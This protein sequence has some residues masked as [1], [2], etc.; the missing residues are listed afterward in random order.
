[1]TLIYRIISLLINAVALMLAVSM[2]F[3]IPMLFSSPQTL[4][5]G[6]LIVAVILYS[7]FSFRFRREVLQKQNQV[8][9]SLRDWVRVNG[10]VTIVFCIISILGLV[11][12]LSNPKPFLET[13]KNFNV[14]MSVQ[15]AYR[16]FCRYAGVCHIASCTH[17]VD[18]CLGE[19]KPG[20]FRIK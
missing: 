16:V 20:L 3:S 6:F 13:V 1:M 12:L 15:K 4:F 17:I 5:P 9:H 18:L 19:K 2:V 11:P 10:I 8:S 7:W 14:D